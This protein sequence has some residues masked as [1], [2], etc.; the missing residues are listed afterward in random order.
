MPP[1][2]RSLS[3]PASRLQAPP[4]P[5][6]P[7]PSGAS[8]APNF[9]AR[10]PVPGNARSFPR[11]ARHIQSVAILHPRSHA[12][13]PFRLL[14]RCVAR[15]KH[16]GTGL[17]FRRLVRRFLTTQFRCGI[18]RILR[19]WRTRSVPG[20]NTPR[21]RSSF[22]LLAVRIEPL[23]GCI[24]V[25]PNGPSPAT[26]AG[27]ALAPLVLSTRLPFLINVVAVQTRPSEF[28]RTNQRKIM[29]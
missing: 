2:S 11:D 27:N 20:A 1:A 14:V 16:V 18:S 26:C 10:C 13:P 9:T 23:V 22:R 21:A 7:S 24:S 15:H 3:S 12:R 19:R 6:I 8:L 28:S 25:R 29:L 4:P 17:H 5:L